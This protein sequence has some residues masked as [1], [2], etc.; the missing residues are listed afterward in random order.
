MLKLIAI[1]PFADVLVRVNAE[2]SCYL[3]N[4][5]DPRSAIIGP[6][7]ATDRMYRMVTGEEP[8]TI[9]I[10]TDSKAI[11]AEQITVRESVYEQNDGVPVELGAPVR[12]MTMKEI[13]AQYLAELTD[14][15]YDGSFESFEEFNDFDMEDDSDAPDS[16]YQ[17][18]VDEFPVSDVEEPVEPQESPEADNVETQE[19]EQNP[20]VA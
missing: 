18:A 20:E 9:A 2:F 19:V 10:E 7:S 8:V 12:E 13:V 17:L 4:E 15:E 16:L 11:I 1:P 6:N 14:R 5:D 3:A